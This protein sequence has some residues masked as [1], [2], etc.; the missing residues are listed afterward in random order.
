MFLKFVF[1]FCDFVRQRCEKEW[2]SIK[3]LVFSFPSS[4][5]P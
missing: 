4:D 1:N 3:D 5:D 2:V